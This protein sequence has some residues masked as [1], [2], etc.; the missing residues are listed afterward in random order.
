MTDHPLHNPSDPGTAWALNAW[1]PMSDP[2]DLKHIGK[3]LEELGEAAAAAAR[4]VIQGIDERE[5][6]TGK[7][8]RQWL[9]EELADVLANIHLVTAHF[10]LDMRAIIVRAEQKK[11][12]LRR[13]HAMLEENAP[14]V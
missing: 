13:W 7:P 6:I 14:G 2:V 3:L 10:G 1:Q 12:H 5:P 8:N 9:Q 4:C 11:K